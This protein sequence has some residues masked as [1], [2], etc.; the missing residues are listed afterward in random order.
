MT[1]PHYNSIN[2]MAIYGI[3]VKRADQIK[4]SQ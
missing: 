3:E 1:V 4:I 2:I